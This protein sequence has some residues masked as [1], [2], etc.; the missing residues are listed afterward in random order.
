MLQVLEL[1]DEFDVDRWLFLEAQTME[2]SNKFTWTWSGARKNHNL[3]LF[4]G[5][6]PLHIVVQYSP[7]EAV[8]DKL[9][10]FLTRKLKVVPEDAVDINGKTPLHIAAAAGCSSHVVA[11]LVSGISAVMPAVA[12]DVM[13]RHA[14]HWA[15]T[16]PNGRAFARKKEL[17][18]DADNSYR[19][20]G[21][22]IETYPEALC[23][24]DMDGRTP[25]D[26]AILNGANERIVNL[27][28]G[29]EYKISGFSAF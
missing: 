10:E 13:G 25:M 3:H 17:A 16:N 21:L 29:D 18:G 28:E 4:R 14:L 20:I 7:T 12:K 1:E 15:C 9:V 24:M 23:L 8:V 6:S 5:E 11:R 2:Q 22:L 26:L 27:L 19:G